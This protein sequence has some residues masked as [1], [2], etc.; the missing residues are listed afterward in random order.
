MLEI[1]GRLRTEYPEAYA[2]Q[3]EHLFVSLDVPSSA[4]KP[5]TV[6][7]HRSRENAFVL[8]PC[9]QVKDC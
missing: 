6:T 5:F 2:I 3:M 4:N 7:G 8:L 9:V 1:L